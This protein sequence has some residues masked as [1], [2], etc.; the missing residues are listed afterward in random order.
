MNAIKVPLDRAE[1][2]KLYL[3]NNNL[4]D[5][6][7]LPNKEEGFIYF[8]IKNEANIDLDFVEAVDKELK[9]KVAE[10]TTLRE[11]LKRYLSD[12]ELNNLKTAFD[13][14]GTI[15]IIEIDESLVDKEQV[16][17]NTL[18]KINKSLKTVV[19]K[20]GIHEG[21]FRTQKLQHLAGEETLE[22]IHKELNISLKL[23]VDKVY[24]SPRLSTER[25]RIAEQVQ[26]GEDILV[27]FSGCAPY[28]C[29]LS[30]NTEAEFIY[31]IEINPEGHKYGLENLKLNKLHNV[32]LLN[33]D[34]KKIV[35]E[36]YKNIIGLK[37]SDN[38]L[39]IQERLVHHPHIMELHTFYEDF[40]EKKDE[41]ER[42]LQLLKDQ[43]KTLIIHMP[44]TFPDGSGISL[45]YENAEK[46]IEVLTILGE[47]CVK[48]NAKA[49]VHPVL[50]KG[51]GVG[52]VK[53]KVLL[54]NLGKI[55]KYFDYFYFE[56]N[57]AESDLF[58]STENIKRIAKKV[59]MKNIC[60][61]VC[62]LYM[63][64]KNMDKLIS[65]INELKDDYNLYF[66]LADTDGERH[67]IEIG[68]GKIDF[69]KLLPVV[70]WG[71]TEVTSKDEFHP[72]EMLRSYEKIM[73]LHKTFDRILMPLPK[74]AED[75]LDEAFLASKEGTII[76]FYDFLSESDIPNAAIDKIQKAADKNNRKIEILSHNKCGQHAPRTFRI[77]VDFKVLN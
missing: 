33:G 22:T 50:R 69:E 10:P 20:V 54:Y 49:I 29:T 59:G 11:A 40:F 4:I 57:I 23:N 36:F 32:I 65:H 9:T 5:F 48:Y 28:P 24:F 56:N 63:H 43:G 52:E 71:I 37:C 44:F 25:K 61:D 34:V 1:E 76:H 3:V 47:L 41:L 68:T 38:T 27:M 58:S 21:E 15:A 62:H 18:L 72:L 6:K 2:A 42:T 16:I 55:K 31:G 75:F 60:V 35:P 74:S 51:E 66:H 17:A 39:Q 64:Y 77:C 19:K 45:H 67:G 8:P 7:R 30:K 46:T 70:S 26:K 53:E 13:T 12:E 73:S 14:V